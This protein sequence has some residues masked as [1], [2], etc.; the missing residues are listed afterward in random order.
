M[1][2][3]A[4]PRLSLVVPVYNVAPF[5]P[6][7]LD[8]L[9]AQT[10][11]ADEIIVVD[12]GST[13]AGPEILRR[14]AER[15]ASITLIR[16]ENQGL[17]GARNTGLVRASGDWLAFVDSDDFLAPDCCEKLL[18][19]ARASD[20][21]IVLGNGWYHFDGREPD[22]PIYRDAPIAGVMSGAAWLAERLARRNLLHMVWLHLYRGDFLRAH[23]F[24]FVP[25]LI[26]E[27]V[28]WTNAV[29]LAAQRVVGDA[30]PHY[31]YRIRVRQFTPEQNDRRLLDTI[32]SS[33][34]N[35][36]ALEEMAARDVHDPQLRRLMRWQLVEGGLAVFHKVDKL[37]SPALRRQRLRAL[38]RAGFFAC[39]WRNAT[40]FRQR[41]RIARNYLRSLG[42]AGV[43]TVR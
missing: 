30:E 17:S 4:A 8:S 33:L 5:L 12:D 21:D 37:S 10:R 29:L 26:H 22:Y 19:L 15:H 18:A 20:A 35:A 27:D 14:Y 43:G 39:L 23:G 24:R 7:C 9:I 41:R 32:D 40:E 38:R 31:Y 25:R 34:T 28:I 1:N 6:Q 16:Q 11:P 42:G 13:D 3:A 36:A 2:G